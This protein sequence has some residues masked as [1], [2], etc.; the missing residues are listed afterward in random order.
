MWLDFRLHLAKSKGAPCEE[1]RQ[2][3]H[4]SFR[5]AQ[6]CEGKQFLFSLKGG[7]AIIPRQVFY[8]LNM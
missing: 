4:E 2:K 1:A 3:G 8:V 7:H 5:V 6:G